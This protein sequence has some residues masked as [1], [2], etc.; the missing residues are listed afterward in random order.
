MDTE[1]DDDMMPSGNAGL[2][3][4]GPQD[5]EGIPLFDIV[6]VLSATLAQQHTPVPVAPF[7]GKAL[8]N[9]QQQRS[10]TISSKT[11]ALLRRIHAT[12]AS[13]AS[14]ETTKLWANVPMRA[15][16]VAAVAEKAAAAAA[17]AAAA[18][19]DSTAATASTTTTPSRAVPK[20]VR[21]AYNNQSGSKKTPAK[22]KKKQ[23]KRKRQDEDEDQKK[24]KKKQQQSVVAPVKPFDYGRATAKAHMR[25]R[26]Q[27]RKLK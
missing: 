10:V 1:D 22:T 9:D 3:D 13:A 27:K 5:P 18:I 12:F 23:K 16:H 14:R 6:G 8:L 11:Q 26:N 4:G 2:V 20:S 24:K 17:A 15:A 25:H 7:P 19:D 21:D